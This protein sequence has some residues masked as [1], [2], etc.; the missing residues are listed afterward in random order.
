MKNAECR[1]Q[2]VNTLARVLHGFCL[3]PSAF[4]ILLVRIYR[5]VLSPA[6][7]FLIGPS[8]KCRFQ[9]SCSQYAL[10]ALKTHGAIDGGW[11]AAKRICRCHPWGDF[12]EDPV[13][14]RKA[15]DQGRNAKVPSPTP[16]GIEPEFQVPT[17]EF[18]I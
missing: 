17:S 16:K 13:P 8:S 2:N 1:M 7:T 10:E 3:L 5:L 12:G 15:K 11:L 18:R 9:P 6:K 4:F 14:P